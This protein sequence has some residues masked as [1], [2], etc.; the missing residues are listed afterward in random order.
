[1]T[2]I[3][4]AADPNDDPTQLAR[5]AAGDRDAFDA[6]VSRYIRPATL[7]AAQLTGDRDEAEDIVQSAFIIVL[8]NASD[9][10]TTRPFRPWL[11][12][13]IRQLAARASITRAR[14]WRLWARWAQPSQHVPSAADMVEAR[15]S[16]DLVASEMQRLPAMQR[17]CLE[18]VAIRGLEISEVALMHDISESTVR[19]HL[20]RARAALRTATAD[21]PASRTDD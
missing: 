1:M 4:R 17:A 11:Y 3:V 5:I 10:D 14:R 7:L 2:D 15:L 12:G 6:L 16:L 20:F 19:Q 13:I 18:L 21:V 9:F 8:E